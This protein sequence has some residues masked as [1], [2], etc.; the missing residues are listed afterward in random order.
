GYTIEAT[1]NHPFLV[2]DVWTHLGQIQPGDRVAV[3]AHTRTNGGS[4]ITDAEIDRAVLLISE[5]D[6]AGPEVGGGPEIPER[7]INAP[8]RK[9]ERFLGR[10]FCNA[11]RADGSGIH[12]G[13]RSQE[14]ARALKRMLLR[15]GVV[16]TVHSCEIGQHG[17]RWT[18][19]VA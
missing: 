6:L 19:S 2:D 3:A 7:V 11:G 9:V 10:Y 15:I 14:V 13:S 1:S 5:G 8:R 4:R 18:L 16:G 12:F 17:R